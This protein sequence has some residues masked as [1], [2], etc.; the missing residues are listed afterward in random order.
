MN[1]RQ[2]ILLSLINCAGGKISRL[3]LVKL[4]FLLAQEYNLKQIN[5]FYQFVPYRY[6]PFSFTLYHEIQSLIKKGIIITPS[7]HELQIPAYLDLCL[8]EELERAVKL[9]WYHY[10]KLELSKLVKIV[11]TNYPWFTAKSEHNT[12]RVNLLP[13]TENAIY[14]AGYEGL[15]VDGFLNLILKTGIQKLIDVRRNPV[16]RRYGFHKTTLSRICQY[17][18]VEYI[19]VP[20][21]GIPSAW[22]TNLCSSFDYEQLFARYQQEILLNQESSIKNIASWVTS[23]PSVLVCYEANPNYCHRSRL[24]KLVSNITGLKV[25]DLGGAELE[26]DIYED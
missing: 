24:A 26:R 9:L 22:R 13:T 12:K 3:R 21:L 15:Q 18:G 2:K 20:E 5:T 11:Y 14:T 6:G 10:G 25:R 19:H 17:L 16:S 4:A 1:M 7:E 23:K 8:E